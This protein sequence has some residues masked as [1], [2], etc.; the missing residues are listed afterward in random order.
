MRAVDRV[1][2]D[3]AEGETVGLIGES[4]SG[5][6]TIGRA[7]LGLT[8]ASDGR[9]LYRGEDITRL[10]AE[11]HSRFSGSQQAVFQ[12]PY[13]SLNPARTVGRSLAEPLEARDGRRAAGSAA[14]I[15]RMLGQVS[16]PAEAADRY[17]HAFSGGQRQR[18]GIA[19]AFATRP[20]LVV[21]DEATSALDVV[22]Q[23]QILGLLQRLGAETGVALLFIA[24]NLPLVAYLAQRVVVLYRGRVMERGPAQDVHEHPLHPYTKALTLAVPSSA[25]AVQRARRAERAEAVRENSANATEPP[26]LG[27]P[28]APRCPS[29]AD[30]CMDSRPADT[31]VGD[32]LIACHLFDPRSGHPQATVTKEV[33]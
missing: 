23:A 16:M 12:D 9:I 4:G 6:T 32:R 5:K 24:H 21:C 22:T 1:S 33:V 28:F 14:E 3:V 8:Q 11:Q 31:P 18:L 19:R 20:E 15:A 29:V 7:V 10:R 13:G 17:P 2:F 26:P 30:V 25:P 27:C